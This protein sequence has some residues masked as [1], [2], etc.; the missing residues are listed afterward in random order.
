M[1]FSKNLES[2]NESKLT[3]PGKINQYRD[4]TVGGCT[5]FNDGELDNRVRTS[6]S[7]I[8]VSGYSLDDWANL[9]SSWDSSDGSG[10]DECVR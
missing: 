3:K 2:S 6:S 8:I 10:M 7:D 9:I 1:Q 4:W 5:V